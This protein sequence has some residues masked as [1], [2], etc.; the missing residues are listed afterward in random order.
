[1]PIATKN[2]HWALASNLSVLP[3]EWASVSAVAQGKDVSVR[4]STFTEENTDFFTVYKAVSN[5]SFVEIAELPAA[6]NSNDL[7]N[8]SIIDSDASRTNAY[9]KIKET[10]FNGDEFWSDVVYY[11]SQSKSYDLSAWFN[12]NN[13]MMQIILPKT[14]SSGMITI[15]DLTGRL[16]FEKNSMSEDLLVFPLN[17]PRNNI[18][19]LRFLNEEGSYSTKFSM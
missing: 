7:R 13:S 9:Y 1:M 14:S 8:Y 15:Y 4:W 3:L 11:K 2:I 10:D 16:L 6:G 19:L 5:S 18:Y 17:L 12:V